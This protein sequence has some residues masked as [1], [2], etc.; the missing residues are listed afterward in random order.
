MITQHTSGPW[1]VE[2]DTTNF[3]GFYQI[4]QKDDLG[5][6]AYR[7][8]KESNAK[9]IAA[10]PD[11]LKALTELADQVA[12][13]CDISSNPKYAT[14]LQKWRAAKQAINKATKL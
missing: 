6:L 7:I 9:L 3:I 4:R 12:Y 5:I 1:I 10:A 14:V 8:N 2:Q 11:L 13:N